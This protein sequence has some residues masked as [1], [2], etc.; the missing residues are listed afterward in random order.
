MM[1]ANLLLSSGFMYFTLFQLAVYNKQTFPLNQKLTGKDHVEHGMQMIIQMLAM[2]S[3]LVLV[4][5]LVL[6]FN[7]TTAYLVLGTIGLIMTLAHPLWLRHIYVRLMKRK[8]ENLE[9]FHASR[10]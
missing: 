1:L 8:Y 6:L 3:P 10:A 4:A 5:A 9:G 7:E 2:F